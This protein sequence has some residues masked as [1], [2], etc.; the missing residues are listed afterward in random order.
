MQSLKIRKAEEKDM[1]AVN[2]IV[3]FYIKN[4]DVILD[5]QPT[6]ITYRLK[7]FKERQD[8]HP[9]FVGEMEEKVIAYASLSQL[10]DKEGYR[11]AAEISVYVKDGLGGRGV[12]AEMMQAAM[13]FAK[14][15]GVISTI[16]SKVTAG[17]AASRAL[18]T[19]FGFEKAG[20]M[21]NVARKFDKFVDVDIYQLFI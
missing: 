8:I 19:K 21:K 2:D 20:T 4:T 10:Y 17:N 14:E 7:W 1:A 11:N 12:G 15:T 6:S 18:H 9:V 5:L 16:I 13:D 3:N